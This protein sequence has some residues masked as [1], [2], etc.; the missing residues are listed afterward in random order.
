VR[1]RR[2]LQLLGAGLVGG[3]AGCSGGDSE[4]GGTPPATSDP[5]TPTATPEP[6]PAPFEHPGTLETTFATN[7]DYP[8]DENPADGYP[9]EFPDPPPAPD[10]DQST[11]D[12]TSTYGETVRL[13][14]IDVVIDWYRRGEAR[15]VDARGLEQYE[16]AHVYGAVFSGAQ[17]KARGGGIDPWDPA[18]R[19][20]TYCACPHHLSSIRAAGL[21]KAGFEEVYALDEGFAGP[22]QDRP[23][24]WANREYP[25]AGTHWLA[26]SSTQR[27]DVT[28][29]GVTDVTYAGEYAWAHVAGQAEAAP[30]ES[31]GTF[32]I[33]G[34]FADV[35]PKSSVTI[36]TPGYT[37]SGA[38]GDLAEGR[39]QPP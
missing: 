6:S 3:L 16:I 10:A 25:M 33:H 19:V 2:T 29:R 31:D 38:L 39:I 14:P 9:P 34:R 17:P 24:A 37:V 23:N 28:L 36:R 12:T 35:S 20:V 13:A 11:F 30:I 1:R 22:Q 21:Q 8:T 5:E 15:F 27:T 7:G 32:A 18:E 4:P 26:E